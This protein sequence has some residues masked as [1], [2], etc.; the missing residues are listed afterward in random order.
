MRDPN[1]P[2]TATEFSLLKPLAHWM[3]ACHRAL[4][5]WSGGLLGRRYNGGE[6]CFVH[7]TGARSGRR[8][9]QPLMYV[10]YGEGVL[11]VA[12]FAGGPEH[13][14]WYHNLR[15][16]PAIEVEWRGKRRPLTARLASA[17]EKQALW[18]LCCRH[19]PDFAL[20]QQRSPRDIPLFICEPTPA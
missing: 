13:P 7:M 6:V 11:L 14:Q 5:R 12:S 1:K 10:P 20:Y 15:A 3:S 16:H 18:P 8:L 19:Y 2:F 4:Y 17:E 9:Q